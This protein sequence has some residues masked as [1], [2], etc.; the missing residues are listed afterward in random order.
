M[1]LLTRVP[2]WPRYGLDQPP[3]SHYLWLKARTMLCS[4]CSMLCC[5]RYYSTQSGVL[6]SWC[7]LKALPGIMCPEHQVANVHDCICFCHTVQRCDA[8]TAEH[9]GMTIS[10]QSM[11]QLQTLV[12]LVVQSSTMHQSESSCS[13]A[14]HDVVPCVPVQSVC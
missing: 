14:L 12:L 13:V 9:A 5:S 2:I 8:K 1:F 7:C 10:H 11:G 4:I 3:P 6:A